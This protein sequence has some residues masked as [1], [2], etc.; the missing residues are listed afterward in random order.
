MAGLNRRI[1]GL[2]LRD[3]FTFV[4]IPLEISHLEYADHLAHRQVFLAKNV[5]YHFHGMFTYALASG[6]V[7][8]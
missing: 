2:G 5:Q 4:F 8:A 7:H 6:D 3:A 1:R